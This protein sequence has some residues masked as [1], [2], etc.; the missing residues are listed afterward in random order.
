M[1]PNV[2]FRFGKPNNYKR[3]LDAY[4]SLGLITLMLAS[5]KKLET[6]LYVNIVRHDNDNNDRLTFE[7]Q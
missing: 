6:I 2:S 4:I 5:I 3:I 1:V 7:H